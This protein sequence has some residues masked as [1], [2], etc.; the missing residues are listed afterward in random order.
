LNAGNHTDIFDL[1]DDLDARRITG[2]SAIG[3]V[4]AFISKNLEWKA[5]IIS[6]IDRNLKTRI[7]ET[8]IS[9]VFPGLIPKFSVA[10]AHPYNEKTQK[11]VDWKAGWYASTKLDGVR[12]ITVID[13][14]GDAQFFSREGN[15]FT[16]L[17]VL[18]DAIR[19]SGL[20]NLVM[21]GEVCIMNG[22]VEDFTLIMKEIKRKDHTIK[23]PAYWVFDVLTHE[24]FFSTESKRRFTERQ[25]QLN[26]LPTMDRIRILEQVRVE[27][28]T[29]LAEIIAAA[30]RANREG[31][32]IRKDAP[33]TGTR[34]N[35]ILKIKTFSDAEYRVESINISVH[36]VVVE[37]REV[38]EEM[39]K[40]CV[41]LHR[42]HPVEV[43]SGF[44]LEQRR[45]IYQNPELLI[46]KT[47]TVQYFEESV[48]Q[49]GK[50]SLRFPVIKQIWDGERDI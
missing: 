25:T 41:I 40:N 36:R 49:N 18:A 17:G 24:E 1:L 9:R 26:E 22:E 21:D 19:A 12:C 11:R 29:H 43:G 48:D 50:H 33:Y 20:K 30:D 39:L 8:L 35:D 42:G 10:L 23:S 31:V 44:S 3:A 7:T 32:M 13:A 47:V 38:E 4:N 16:T 5:I 6:I 46:G 45:Q 27:S 14:D 37:G 2:H 34:S 15:P 28:D